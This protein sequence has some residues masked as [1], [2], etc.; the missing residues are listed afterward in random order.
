ML[1]IMIRSEKGSCLK[2]ITAGRVGGVRIRAL[3]GSEQVISR[4]LLNY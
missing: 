2:I 3:V 1:C 4:N